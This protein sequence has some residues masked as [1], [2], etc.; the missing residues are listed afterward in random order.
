MYKKGFFQNF[1]K[2]CSWHWQALGTLPRIILI[3]LS[4]RKMLFRILI[5]IFIMIFLLWKMIG[6]NQ[7]KCVTYFELLCL[8]VSPFSLIFPLTSSCQ[9]QSQSCSSPADRR[10][11]GK[12][13]QINN[14][15]LYRSE[16]YFVKFITSLKNICN[17]AFGL[18]F[19]ILKNK[20]NKIANLQ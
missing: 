18:L 17:L 7:N 9:Q 10:R 8:L 3:M 2:Y 20:M 11:G 19:N 13:N 4:P 12:T 1:F 5:F 15:L 16:K 14:I 6:F